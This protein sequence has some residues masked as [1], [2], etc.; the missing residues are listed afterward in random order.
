MFGQYVQVDIMK[1]KRIHGLDQ[2]NEY[3]NVYERFVLKDS[4]KHAEEVDL[5]ELLIEDFDNR[6]IAL[7]G[8]SDDMN[9]VEVL[10]YLIDENN[11]SKAE[12]ARQLN[13]SRQLITEIINYKRN[14]SKKMIMKLSERFK[15]RPIAFSR[16]YELVPNPSSGPK[17]QLR[18]QT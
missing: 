9:P 18:F 16:E 15:M 4:G 17:P 12:L 11:I 8:K 14:I 2:Y 10:Q 13:V 1:Y 6:T 3:C 7:I 5:L